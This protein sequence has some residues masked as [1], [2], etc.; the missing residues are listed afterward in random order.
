MKIFGR[1]HV[2]AT[3]YHFVAIVFLIS[4][5]LWLAGFVSDK[6][7]LIITIVLFVTDYIAE[8]YDPHPDNPG[9]WF[10][11][12]F[13]RAFDNDDNDDY[14]KCDFTELVNRL[15]V[16]AEEFFKKVKKG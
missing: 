12:H 5:T 7:S 6:L 16:E 2:R 4:T 8:L 15:D 1:H 11:T 13:H 3:F 9:P 14:E 10:K